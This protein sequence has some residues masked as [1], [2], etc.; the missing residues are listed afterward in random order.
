MLIKTNF[1]IMLN[2]AHALTQLFTH[3]NILMHT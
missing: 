1:S 3:T 2:K